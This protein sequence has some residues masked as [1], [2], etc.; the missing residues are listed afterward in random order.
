M[1]EECRPVWPAARPVLQLTD[2]R[3][4]PPRGHDGQDS[5]A[6]TVPALSAS[7]RHASQPH[8]VRNLRPVTCPSGLTTL[9]VGCRNGSPTLGSD[10]RVHKWR[11]R[12]E[13][14]RAYTHDGAAEQDQHLRQQTQPPPPREQQHQRPGFG[15]RRPEPARPRR[16]TLDLRRGAQRRPLGHGMASVHSSMHC[17]PSRVAPAR[18]ASRQP[19]QAGGNAR[20]RSLLHRLPKTPVTPP[21]RQSRARQPPQRFASLDRL[22]P[23]LLAHFPPVLETTH[24]T[25]FQ[26]STTL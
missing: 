18:G 3:T 17:S 26:E 21:A 13:E 23:P 20:E 1:C 9:P 2:H 16:Y 4:A 19:D 10:H 24:P 22:A 11:N 8:S 6:E 5:P 7:R 14:L 12:G 25:W 15:K